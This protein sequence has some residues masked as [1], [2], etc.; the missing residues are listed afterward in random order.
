VK[1]TTTQ[2]GWRP[3]VSIDWKWR[4]WISDGWGDAVVQGLSWD[5]PAGDVYQM[6]EKLQPE[7][8]SVPVYGFCSL[9]LN[10][11]AGH[12]TN[13]LTE[14][15]RRCVAICEKSGL[16]GTVAHQSTDFEFGG[17]MTDQTPLPWQLLKVK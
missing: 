7:K 16:S 12:S 15:M 17:I 1:D 5:L 4:E 9:L 2:N 3:R 11:G 14:R 10:S 6:V 8:I 13:E